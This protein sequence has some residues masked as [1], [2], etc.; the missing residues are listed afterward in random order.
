MS[1]DYMACFSSITTSV[2]TVSPVCCS[3]LITRPKNVDYFRAMTV[4]SCLSVW[5]S[6]RTCSL[7][8]L[9]VP[10]IL[11]I[12]LQHRIYM[13]ALCFFLLYFRRRQPTAIMVSTAR[14]TIFNGKLSELKHREK[15]LIKNVV[16]LN[17]SQ[18][19]I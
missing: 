3:A 5:T 14:G 11:H 4:T 15:N 8:T 12:C 17:R 6:L 2:V 1:N 9:A 18:Y 10:V 19:F 16:K 13:A 7:L